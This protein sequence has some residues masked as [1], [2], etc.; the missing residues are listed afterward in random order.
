MG[1]VYDKMGKSKKAKESY[2]QSVAS[3]NRRSMYDLLY[4]Q[5]KSYEKLGD[6]DK[7]NEMFHSLI[8]Q[9]Q[10]LREAGA[11]NTLIAVE[12]GSSRNN[13]AISQSYFLEAL[14]NRGLGN[15]EEAHRLFQSALDEYNHN[16]WAKV[17]MNE[18]GLP[19]LK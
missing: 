14:G 17:M 18:E 5:A 11:D 9:G 13:K 1:E 8:S 4:Y 15:K 10:E 7:A 2:Q 16:L 12:E 19:S 6:T 3:E